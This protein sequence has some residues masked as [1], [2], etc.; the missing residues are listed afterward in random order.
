[1]SLG[2]E[3]GYALSGP[4]VPASWAIVLLGYVLTTLLIAALVDRLREE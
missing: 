4:G 2:Q 1:V 3:D